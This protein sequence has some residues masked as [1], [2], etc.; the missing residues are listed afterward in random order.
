MRLELSTDCQVQPQPWVWRLLPLRHGRVGGQSVLEA[1]T[2]A[3]LLPP[4][5]L[6]SISSPLPPHI[7]LLHPLSHLYPQSDFFS[8]ILQII[9]LLW[10]DGL[11]TICI[12]FSLQFY[13]TICICLQSKSSGRLS[14]PAAAHFLD[15][16]SAALATEITVNH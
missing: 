8:S 10:N 5:F 13:C 11:L 6:P 16:L 1:S 2:P 3:P 4:S 12:S 9:Y 15:F 14:I 7:D